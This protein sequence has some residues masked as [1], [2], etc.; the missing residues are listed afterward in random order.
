MHLLTQRARDTLEKTLDQPLVAGNYFTA[1]VAPCAKA[2]DGTLSQ[3][4]TQLKA[5]LLLARLLPRAQQ[6]GPM[7]AG[8]SERLEEDMGVILS[9]LPYAR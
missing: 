3:K 6:G 4:K 5:A 8:E 9:G 7:A 2:W 1:A